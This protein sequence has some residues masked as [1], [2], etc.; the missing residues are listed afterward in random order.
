M[1]ETLTYFNLGA[2]ALAIRLAYQYGNIT[3][4]DKRFEFSEWPAVKPTTPLGQLPL[5][6]YA[7]SYTHLT[8]PTKA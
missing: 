5:L 3:Y 4:N 8:L 6:E 7:V 2:R 1:P